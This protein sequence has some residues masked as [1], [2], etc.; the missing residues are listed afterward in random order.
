M[1]TIYEKIKWI[2]ELVSEIKIPKIPDWEFVKQTDNMTMKRRFLPGSDIA[3]FKSNGLVKAKTET[4]SDFIWNVFS[5]EKHMEVNDPNILK[6]EVIENIDE[7]TRKL[8]QTKFVI[9]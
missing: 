2:K 8:L 4:L 3:C 6:Y 1:D 5:N 9:I 7:N